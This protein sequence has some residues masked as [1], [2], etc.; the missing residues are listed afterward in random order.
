M[1]LENKSIIHKNMWIVFQLGFQSSES[2][3]PI[4]AGA[5]EGW[6]E[7]ELDQFTFVSG[8]VKTEV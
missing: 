6:F 8:E 2:F 5:L 7:G 3:G 4:R 1:R